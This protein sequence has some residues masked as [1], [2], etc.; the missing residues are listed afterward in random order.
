MITGFL[1]RS[2]FPLPWG[3]T[4]AT[5]ALESWIARVFCGLKVSSNIL[6]YALVTSGLMKVAS[7]C[8]QRPM[9]GWCREGGGLLCTPP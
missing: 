2:I 1:V 3:Y 7:S 6:I 4:A 8:F 9:E 5:S